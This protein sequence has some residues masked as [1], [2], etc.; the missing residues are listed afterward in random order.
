M[1]VS[2]VINVA[3]ECR[4]IVSVEDSNIYGG[5]GGAITEVLAE[6]FIVIP[7]KRIDVK[8]VFGQSGNVEDLK[9]FYDLSA[10]HI[11]NAVKEVLKLKKENLIYRI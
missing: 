3:R 6:N 4:A 10:K 1:D 5:L 7:F 9:E 2:S 8:D 11:V